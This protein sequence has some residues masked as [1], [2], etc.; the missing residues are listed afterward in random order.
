[1]NSIVFRAFMLLIGIALFVFYGIQ[2][3]AAIVNLPVSLVGFLYSSAG[4]TSSVLCFI[5]F[6]TRRKLLLIIVTPFALL[7]IITL[8]KF[9]K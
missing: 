6:Y 5:Y 1:M 3:F 4:V 8:L 2:L 7:M 9:L